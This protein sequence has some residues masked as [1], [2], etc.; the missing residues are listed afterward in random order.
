VRCLFRP[1][2]CDLALED[3]A[4]FVLILFCPTL[5]D[6]RFI[7]PPSFGGPVS[8]VDAF[9]RQLADDHSAQIVRVRREKLIDAYRL[10][11]NGFREKRLISRL[12]EEIDQQV[13]KIL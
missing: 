12:C 11:S 8:L 5:R 13:R 4:F 6:L 9:V 10:E 7:G 2:R 3:G 1:L